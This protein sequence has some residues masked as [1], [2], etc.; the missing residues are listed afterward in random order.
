[1]DFKT[2]RT[3]HRIERIGIW[4]FTRQVLVHQTEYLDV[5]DG[6]MMPERNI[7]VDTAPEWLLTQPGEKTNAP[8]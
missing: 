8:N 2:G 1:M 4:P 6:H 7:W 3:R 5:G